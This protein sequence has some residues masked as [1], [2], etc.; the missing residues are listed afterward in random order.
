MQSELKGRQILESRIKDEY[1]KSR[2][3]AKQANGNLLKVEF[4]R[5]EFAQAEKAAELMAQ[6]L[7]EVRTERG[8]L[9]GCRC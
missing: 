9:R 5:D 8:R 4:K 6:R 3:D 2:G 1:E 7:L